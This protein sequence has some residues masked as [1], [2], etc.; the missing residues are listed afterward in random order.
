M[1]PPCL[2]I[3]LAGGQSKRMGQDKALMPHPLGNGTQNMLQYSEQL[4][5]NA[6]M[7]Q[8]LI[9]R[10]SQN[11]ND[12]TGAT[13]IRDI[14]KKAGPLGGLYSV[15]QHTSCDAVLM[16]PVDLP[17]MTAPMLQQ[18]RQ[19]GERNH[20]AC[21]FEGHSLPLYLPI[22]KNVRDF[23]QHEF[24]QFNGKGPAIK[25]LLKQVPHTRITADE[26]IK[27]SNTNTP[28]QWQDAQQI[29]QSGI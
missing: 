9:S 17:L 27:L 14:Y 18:L 29:L 20:S 28:E 26:P 24:A 7:E 23:L 13:G 16:L 15:L 22:D 6:G 25:H 5:Q 21:C 4:F 10:D 8:V 3:I 2:G 11:T 12:V 1:N 19:V